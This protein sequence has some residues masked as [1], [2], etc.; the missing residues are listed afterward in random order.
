[1]SPFLVEESRKSFNIGAC[2]WIIDKT[3]PDEDIKFYLYTRLNPDDREMVH[4]DESWESSNLSMS[5][6]NPQH[7]VKIIIHGYNSDMFL[8][9]LID[10]KKGAKY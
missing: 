4:I 7:S 2:T 9:P 5:N 8:T 3:C 10:M 1:M 6:F